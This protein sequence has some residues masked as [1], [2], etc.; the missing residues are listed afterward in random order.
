MAPSS[1][2]ERV[3]ARTLQTGRETPRLED[4]LEAIYHLIHD[5][6]YE[7]T[8]DISDRLEVKPPTVSNMVQK[9]AKRG[10]L[11]HEPYRGM[12]LTEKG[13]KLAKSVIARHSIVSEFLS[14]IGVEPKTAYEDTEGIE[15]H[16]QPTTINRLERVV[17]FLKENPSYLEAL[18][19]YIEK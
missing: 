6:G 18:R 17:S 7:S 10:Y 16:V 14:M 8:V 11:V 4:Y 2:V 3:L 9:L 5:K 13:E 1:S 19:E 12:R 15:H